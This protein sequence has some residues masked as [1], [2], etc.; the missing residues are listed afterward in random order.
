MVPTTKRQKSQKKKKNSSQSKLAKFI[1]SVDG[2]VLRIP[3]G[4]YFLWCS[5]KENTHDLRLETHLVMT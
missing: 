2:H 5:F 4:W 3:L 1:I